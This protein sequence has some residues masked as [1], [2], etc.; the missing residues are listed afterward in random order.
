M[1][2]I[3]L[4]FRNM[5]SYG[6][7]DQVIEFPD[8]ASF[9]LVQGDNGT[10]KCLDG[11][12]EIPIIITDKKL[13]KK[14]KEFTRSINQVI[15]IC[16]QKI[17]I[18]DLLLFKK[19]LAV[20][21]IPFDNINTS[22]RYGIKPIADVAITARNEPAIKLIVKSGK[23]IICSKNHLL[24]SPVIG[25]MKSSDFGKGDPIEMSYGID[26][27]YSITD[28]GKI[29][30]LYD[31]QINKY[32]EFFA[33]DFVSHNSTIS[34]TM[35]F[36]W[37]GR[38]EGKN[39]KDIVNR[40]N[41]AAYVRGEGIIRGRQVVVERG[42]SPNIMTLEVDGIPYDKANAKV[43]PSDYLENELLEIPAH[44]FN[45]AICLSIKD[46]KS[47]L[48]MSAKDKRLLIDRIFAFQIINEMKETLTK[49]QSQ[50]KKDIEQLDAQLITTTRSYNNSINEVLLLTK[51]LEEN[52]TDKIIL[53]QGQLEKLTELLTHHQKILTAFLESTKDHRTAV[54]NLNTAKTTVSNKISGLRHQLGLYANKQCPTCQSDLTSD[55]HT[56]IKVGI[57][58]EI[59]NLDRQLLD[60]NG[61]WDQARIMEQEQDDKKRDFV[62][63]GSKI[64]SK[65]AE[66]KT[67]L[68]GLNNDKIDDQLTSINKIV[69][70]LKAD[71]TNTET[72]KN[73]KD[74]KH[75]WFKILENALSD[76]GI[77]QLAMQTITPAFN[78]EI[79]RMMGE[80][81]M[82][83]Q[84]IFDEQFDA[85]IMHLGEEI[86]PATLSAGESVKVDFV[87]LVSFIRLLKMKFPSINVMFL[88]EIFA[89]VDM[90]GIYTICKILKRIVKELGLN[91]F[92]VSH[93]PL[94]TEMFEY[95]IEVKK[96]NGFSNLKIIKIE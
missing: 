16:K 84:V 35:Q 61:Q 94:P 87:I 5:A 55:F 27:V 30:L 11:D 8:E 52:N 32:Q 17:K 75:S 47:F 34:D 7:R 92:V 48:K 54:H 62:A 86:S 6:E 15:N 21:D 41:S 82:N 88:D 57:E 50:V 29:D 96:E 74:T 22:T 10:G 20:K 58:T 80:M 14:Y 90:D 2:L 73:D 24:C 81:H 95:K 77:K 60:L 79:Y 44:V 13:I 83:Y 70:Q 31:L 23:S 66:V 91:I 56:N 39:K 38:V 64:E 1:K 85:R 42:I 9:F 59:A 71:I 28:I 53:L 89:S 51:K 78:A 65:I 4:T 3:K 18:K 37:Y 69:E 93:A 49:L 67:A 72:V 33:N 12:T 68:K 46:F 43:G 76:K 63:K 25:W 40:L 19:W 26:T 45:N 36:L